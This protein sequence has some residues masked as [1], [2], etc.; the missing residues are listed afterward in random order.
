MVNVK[1]KLEKGYV[2]F[3]AISEIAGKPKEHVEKAI[4]DY[5]ERIKQNDEIIIIKEEIAETKEL[6]EENKG[7]FSTFAELE[8]MVPDVT[9]LFGFC[10]DYMPS[11]VDIIEPVELKISGRFTSHIAN[12]LQAKL[13]KLDFAIKQTKNE[14]MSLQKNMHLLLRNT[15][16][17]LIGNKGRT[18]K[19]LAIGVGM[20]EKEMNIFL[21][22]LVKQGIFVKQ[23]ELFKRKN[24]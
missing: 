22:N 19:E 16:T 10:F 8:L 12:D 14:N 7:L 20:E 1:E 13:H 9:K 4:K 21:E 23:G 15:V 11:S 18:A 6:E 17:I 3:K 5:V 24:G 2:Q